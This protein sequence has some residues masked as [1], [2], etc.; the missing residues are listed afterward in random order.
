MVLIIGH[1]NLLDSETLKRRMVGW[2]IIVDEGGYRE[3]KQQKSFSSLQV[4]RKLFRQQ[5]WVISCFRSLPIRAFVQQEVDLH[6]V[7]CGV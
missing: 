2:G 6:F 7:Q 4:G 5:L 1:G 3:E